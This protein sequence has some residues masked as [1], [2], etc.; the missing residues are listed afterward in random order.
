MGMPFYLLNNC[1][2]RTQESR[3][4]RQVAIHYELLH[5]VRLELT[6]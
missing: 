3:Q 1:K 5:I 6:I 2:V 4:T